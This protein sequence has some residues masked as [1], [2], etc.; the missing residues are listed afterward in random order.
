MSA[1]LHGI[2]RRSSRMGLTFTG[3]ALDRAAEHRGD[4]EWLAAQA[5]DPAARAV[6][7]GDDGIHLTGD[8]RLALVPLTAVDA[9]EPLLLGL[10]GAGPVFA[11]DVDPDGGPRPVIA[12]RGEGP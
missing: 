4:A 8:E 9:P 7:A 12:D 11:V 2:A 3:E 5:A 10:D 6:L 1:A